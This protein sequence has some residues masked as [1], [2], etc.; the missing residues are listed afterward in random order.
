MNL[1]S[2]ARYVPKDPGG[3]FIAS[4]VDAAVLLAVTGWAD[5]VLS[6]AQQLVPVDTG[7]LK[8]SGHLEVSQSGKTV[9]AAVVFDAP[10][11]VYVEFGT[12]IRGAASPG[13]GDGPYSE[14]WPGMA[15]QPYLR[16]AFDAHRN[17]A[18]GMTREFVGVA[19]KA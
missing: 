16:P 3:R 19:L 13:A 9:A 5:K 10:Y 6:T 1:T 12:G 4:I 7:E 14:S 18:E 15:A 2:Y 8:A 11:S 17:E